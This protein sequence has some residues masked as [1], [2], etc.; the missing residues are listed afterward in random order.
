MKCCMCGGKTRVE[1]GDLDMAELGL[2]NVSLRGIEFVCCDAC[3]SRDPVIPRLADLMRTIAAAFLAKPARLAGGEMKF[4]RTRAEL[5]QAQMGELLH[6]ARTTITKWETGEWPIPASTDVAVR[7]VI[8]LLD[9]GLRA[10]A[11]VIAEELRS[12]DEG[13]AEPIRVRIDA[14]TLHVSA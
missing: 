7:S 11:E 3:G 5:T 9:D 14:N 10:P 4:L 12:I 6:V 8:R 13:N 2:P 1:K